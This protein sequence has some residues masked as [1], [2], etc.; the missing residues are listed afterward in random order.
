MVPLQAIGGQELGMILT[1]AFV[2]TAIG[3][4]VYRFLEGYVAGRS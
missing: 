4:T 3:Y 1:T 2:L